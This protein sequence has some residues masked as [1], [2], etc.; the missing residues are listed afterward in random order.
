MKGMCF[1]NKVY[2]K[3]SLSKIFYEILLLQQ[4]IKWLLNR[5]ESAWLIILS[6]VSIEFL[7]KKGWYWGLYSS[8]SLLMTWMR[9]L[10][11]ASLSLQITQSWEEVFLSLGVGR[12]YR[13][14]WVSWIA[15][16]RPTGRGSTRQSASSC[17]LATTAP[18]NA[19][20]CT[21]GHG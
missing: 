5:V 20:C 16:L 3:L 7:L 21:E 13:G 10:S 1:K 17:T 2:H 12:P 14:I 6:S 8:I 4:I 15:G 19:T 18:G 9:A 11:A